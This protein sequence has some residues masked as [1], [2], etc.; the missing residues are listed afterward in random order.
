MIKITHDKKSDN[1]HSSLTFKINLYIPNL[2]IIGIEAFA[3][4]V[5]G[6][7]RGRIRLLVLC[8]DKLSVLYIVVGH[9][10]LYTILYTP[11][12]LVLIISL[13]ASSALTLDTFNY[14]SS[15]MWCTRQKKRIAPL[16]FFHGCRKKINS[17]HT[18]H[19]ELDGPAINGRWSVIG[20]WMGD[21]KFIISS[22]SVLRKAR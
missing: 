5:E 17:S 13:K 20:H 4:S 1:I 9:I 8:F 12:T 6:G 2:S 3:E 10:F 18:W 15:L 19:E 14:L 21:Q 11:L 7:W 22:S 16:P